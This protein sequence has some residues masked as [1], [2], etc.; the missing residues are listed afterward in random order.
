MSEPSV[1]CACP[2]CGQPI[3]EDQRSR[4][5]LLMA[6]PDRPR[7]DLEIADALMEQTVD[8]SIEEIAEE[9]LFRVSE[10]RLFQLMALAQLNDP[11]RAVF[12]LHELTEAQIRD[13]LPIGRKDPGRLEEAMRCVGELGLTRD[14]GAREFAQ[15]CADHPD[16]PPARLVAPWRAS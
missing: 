14:G 16:V 15:A 3:P 6:F 13:L 4:V 2:A 1:T 7:M 10:R 11:Q 9:I 12:I 5:I 8:K